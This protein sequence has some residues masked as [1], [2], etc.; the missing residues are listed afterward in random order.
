MIKAGGGRAPWK[1]PHP[2]QYSHRQLAGDG[3]LVAPLNGPV[4]LPLDACDSSSR[5]L[6]R[7][8]IPVERKVVLLG[9]NWTNWPPLGTLQ[10]LG[11]QISWQVRR[12]DRH[13]EGRKSVSTF[14]YHR[15]GVSMDRTKMYQ[16]REVCKPCM[17]SQANRKKQA[18]TVRAS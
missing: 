4:L 7:Y 6:R 16:Q 9:G 11:L 1:Q 3:Q 10:P 17:E 2:L 5:F 13:R 18:E 8:F 12:G 15:G 14:P